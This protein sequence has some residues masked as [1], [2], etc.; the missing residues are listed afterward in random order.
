[1]IVT[2]PFNLDLPFKGNMF[3]VAHIYIYIGRFHPFVG[4]EGP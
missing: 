2:L 4:H 3:I 1:M